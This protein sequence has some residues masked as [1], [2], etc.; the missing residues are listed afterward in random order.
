MSLS[1]DAQSACFDPD[2]LDGAEDIAFAADPLTAFVGPAPRGPVDRP[3]QLSSAADFE[4]HFGVPG[5]R[6]RMGFA[7]RQFFANGGG[8]AWVVRVSGTMQRR[9]VALPG[10]AGPL[11]LRARNPGPLEFL[12]ASVDYDGVADDSPQAFNLIVQRLRA[13][14]SIWIEEQE[15]FRRVTVM[16]DSRDYIGKVLEQSNLVSLAE[17][18]PAERPALTIK[19]GSLREAGYVAAAATP[20]QNP[21]PGD[22]DLI[23][24]AAAGTGLNALRGLQDIAS[25]CLISGATDASIGPV[26]MVAADRFCRERQALLIVDPP[27]R[28]RTVQDVVSDQQRSGFQSPNAVTWFPCT[29]V[30][31]AAGESV[32]ASAAG[33]VAA[34]LASRVGTRDLPRLH[35]GALVMQRGGA[36]LDSRLDAHDLQRLARAGVNSLVRRSANHHELLG[37]V[38]QARHAAPGAGFRELEQRRD[39]LFILRRIRLG[40]RWLAATESGPQ[41][42]RALVTQVQ[43]FLAALQESGMLAGGHRA[44]GGF[45]RCDAQTNRGLPPGTVAFTVAMT[46]AGA[47]RALTYRFTQAATGCRISELGKATELALTG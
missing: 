5:F 37:K 34:A 39:V 43:A 17:P 9:V 1:V 20:M 3:V 42:W 13:D 14:A 30:R 31:D 44:S 7:L 28:W 19:A 29:R 35:D 15:Y 16:P 38:T 21:A 2:S 8:S 41:Q 36:Q 18:A 22:Y 27:A 26:A 40:T 23:G 46:L 24:A 6:C 47:T 25:V 33:A 11:L 45:V 10:P 32:L 4:K 12:R